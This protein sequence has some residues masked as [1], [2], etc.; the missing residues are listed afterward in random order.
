[1]PFFCLLLVKLDFEI[2]A[3]IYIHLSKP[4]INLSF[5][6][7]FMMNINLFTVYVNN[8]RGFDRLKESH[9]S[10]PDEYSSIFGLA[11]KVEL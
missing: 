8:Y 6:I 11:L 5:L 9:A 4:K 3:Q 7:F 2:R 10:S 1:M